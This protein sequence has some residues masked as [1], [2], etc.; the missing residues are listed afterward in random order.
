M[1]SLAHALNATRHHQIGG[2]GL[3]PHRGINHRLQPRAAAAIHLQTRNMNAEPSVQS[4]NATNRRR[5]TIGVALPKNH[6][7]DVCT[8][9]AGA[10][11]QGA[12]DSLGQM[13]RRDAF[14]HPTVASH[15]GSNRFTNDS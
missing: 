8:R 10:A 4:G 2:A 3:H 12:Q 11:D 9:N 15:R 7:I 13:G 5:F 1:F 14:E 6:I